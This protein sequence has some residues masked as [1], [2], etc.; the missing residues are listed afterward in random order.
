MYVANYKQIQVTSKQK[1]NNNFVSKWRQA[2]TKDVLKKL[3][4]KTW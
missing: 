2:F 4:N 3:P 1:Y